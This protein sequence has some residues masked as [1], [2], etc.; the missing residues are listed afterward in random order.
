M[1]NFAE[2]YWITQKL[3][4]EIS[5]KKKSVIPKTITKN[6]VVSQEPIV[7][8]KVN[9]FDF[10]QKSTQEPNAL[11][12]IQSIPQK[13][14]IQQ[15]TQKESGF[16]I[17]PK[18]SA[19]DSSSYINELQYDI[20]N[21]ATKEEIQK[22]YPELKSNTKLIDELHYDISNWATVDEINNAYPE[23]SWAT[24]I[25]QQPKKWKSF[26]E[27]FSPIW[28]VKEHVPWALEKTKEIFT[29]WLKRV[30]EAWNILKKDKFALWEAWLTA[31]AGIWQSVLSPITWTIWEVWESVIEQ[32][33]QWFKD[34][35]W[36]KVAPTIEDVKTWYDSQSD[37]QKKNLKGLWLSVETLSNFVWWKVASPAIQKTWTK[38]IKI[39][40]QW[41]KQTWKVVN[42]VWKSIKSTVTPTLRATEDIS[43]NILQPYKWMTAN[44]DDANKWL[45]RVV[46][47]TW[48]NKKEDFAWLYNKA[49]E[50]KTKY[51]KILETQLDNVPWVSN[52]KTANNALIQLED[53]YKWTVSQKNQWV[54]KRIQELTSKNN[55]V[56]LSAKEMNEVKVLHT[57]A[58]KL[59]SEKWQ[60]TWWFSS[61]DL[62]NIRNELKTE[63]E[64]FASSK[65]VTNLKDINKIYW[66]LSNTEILLK[67]QI[68][69]VKSFKWRQLP[70][71][72]S[73]KVWEL[74]WSIPIIKWWLQG[75]LK[76]AG[77]S[78]K[79][80]TI[81]PI[82]IQKRLPSLLKELRKAWL[83]QSEINNV[84]IQIWKEL[85]KAL[86]SAWLS[87]YKAPIKKPIITPQTV[88]KWII[89]ESKK[90]LEKTKFWT[91]WVNTW[92]ENYKFAKQV[93]QDTDKI[94]DLKQLKNDIKELWLWKEKE[95]LNEI[96]SKI[97]WIN[98]INQIENISETVK[99]E[100]WEDLIKSFQKLY[101]NEK[102]I[103]ISKSWDKYSKVEF[104]KTPQAKDFSLS[105]QEYINQNPWWWETVQDLYDKLKETIL[106]WNKTWWKYWKSWSINPWKIF[107]DIKNIWKSI[108]KAIIN[109]NIGKAR[110]EYDRLVKNGVSPL[111]AQIEVSKK[112]NVPAYKVWKAWTLWLES[113]I[114]KPVNKE[115]DS[116]INKIIK[117]TFWNT[118]IKGKKWLEAEKIYKLL[119]WEPTS[120]KV[121]N[122]LKKLNINYDDIPDKSSW[123]WYWYSY[124]DRV[125]YADKTD[126]KNI[127]NELWWYKESK[128]VIPKKI[129]TEWKKSIKLE[130][131]FKNSVKSQFPNIPKDVYDDFIE[132]L[133]KEHT[134]KI[135]NLFNKA[136]N[137]SNARLANKL[138]VEYDKMEMHPYKIT[139]SKDDYA[140]YNE[141]IRRKIEAYARHR[142][143]D[144]DTKI[145]NKMEDEFIWAQDW[146]KA[147]QETRSSIREDVD[148]IL[149]K[150]MW[151]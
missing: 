1:P 129:I 95:L 137:S 116:N 110:V 127:I 122:I 36:T 145:S 139:I 131:K 102:K 68:A 15:P 48:F 135:D 73:Q 40:K 89:Q 65:W 18:V 12:F 99:R 91:S 52:S 63:I 105:A 49:L 147:K 2:T 4:S 71:T 80:G 16:S 101:W 130:N 94:D 51:W 111:K 25:I 43:A 121:L 24:Q 109:P 120:R 38:I 22:A 28:Q 83:K 72:F 113:K 92:A 118:E 30:W 59:F 74:I 33:P 42:Q 37:M 47:E 19:G 87:S 93:I 8:P 56:W 114:I 143:T 5:D 46:K 44:L 39:W 126:I 7:K 62:R 32:I 128:V 13:Q 75:I 78:I 20:K 26:I 60:A 141:I 64:D 97:N 29:G 96:D 31:I 77:V 86:P 58:N 34:Y 57:K 100:Y 55:T 103:I 3:T 132:T 149:E 11:Q 98:E 53:I 41:A 35:I 90:W 82:E 45:Q 27:W 125:I 54:L 112:Y 23:L 70:K 115:L 136:N 106:K 142:Y 84:Q 107:E 123:N 104:L 117:N 61:D 50:T 150:W 6:T 66:E 146:S 151:L 124:K 148:K 133:Q 10:S 88:N 21:W 81:N 144:Y 14:V 67:N 9:L 69:S 138:M 140:D 119:P 76:Q 85:Q 134:R 17:I 79:A 108:K